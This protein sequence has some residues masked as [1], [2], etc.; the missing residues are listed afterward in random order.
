MTRHLLSLLL[1]FTTAMACTPAGFADDTLAVIGPAEWSSRI[2]A[3]AGEGDWSTVDNLIS[4]TPAGDEE[5]LDT[6]RS[7]VEAYR[8]H[9][10]LEAEDTALSRAEAVTKMNEELVA[11]HVV[12]AMQ[13]A[14]KA[15]TLSDDFDQA[16]LDPDVQKVLQAVESD[17]RKHLDEGDFLMAQT[18]LYYM[19]TFYEDTSRRDLYDR[20][21]AMLD[22]AS[23]QLGLLRK[24][25]PRHLHGLWGKRAEAL[26]DEQ[27]E[28]YSEQA[29]DNW[30]ERIDGIEPGIII[31]SLPIAATEHMQEAGWNPLIVGGLTG[32]RRLGTTPAIAETFAQIAD[33]EIREAWVAGVDKELASLAERLDDQQ[34]IRV[35]DLML[36]RLE[37]LNEAT[38]DLPFEVVVREFGD[39]SMS[40]LDRY[41]GIIW[42][43]ESRRFNQQTEGR[44]VGV[45]VVI[46]ENSKGE[47]MVVNPIEGAPA[48]YGGVQPGDVIQKVDGRSTAGWSL[49]DAVDRITGPRGTPVALTIRRGEDGEMIDFT[50]TRATVK[51]HSVQGWW[52]EGLDDE[53]QPIWDWMIDDANRIAYVKLTGFSEETYRDLLTAIREMS[54]D[55]VPNGLVLDLR[56]NPGGLLPIARRI[57]NLFVSSGTIVSG[58]DSNGDQLFV[59]GARPS[60]AYLA[61]WPVVVLINQGS[62]SASEIVSGCVQ[63]HAAGVVVGERSWG[64]GSVQTVH[65]VSDEAALKLTTQYY[66][67]PSPD[68]GTTPG[69]LVHKQRGSNDW[70][71]VPDLIVRM[72]PDQVVKT[73]ELRQK[74]NVLAVEGPDERP[75]VDDLLEKGLDPQLETAVLLLRATAVSRHIADVRQ[76]RAD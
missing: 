6:F 23:V 31:G 35:L 29:A 14:V 56:Y 9:R 74:A 51:L 39:G 53:G 46:R 2:W 54:A 58:E 55:G 15:Q 21:D 41:S 61:D 33:G 67:L 37:A 57:A 5:L 11:G 63:A 1:A 75:S 72:S 65:P 43:D 70:G 71:V 26:G 42:P 18:L 45:G 8:D 30:R 62:A 50:L 66:R 4:K 68:G 38:I 16:M 34:G 48:Y 40:T 73:N 47:I 36:R 24:Y 59:M 19:R 69:R 25:A 32:V 13:S 7:Q 10:A 60:W 3:A 12:L 27:P 28:E 44:F 20:W 49:N 17:I 76:A 22:D 52:K 64:K